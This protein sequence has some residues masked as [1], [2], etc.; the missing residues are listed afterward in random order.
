MKRSEIYKK[1]LMRLEAKKTTLAQRCAASEDAAEVRSL[2][3]ELEDVNNEIAECRD[4]ISAAEAEERSDD[5][6]TSDTVIP[7]DA[8]SVNGAQVLGSYAQPAAARPEQ[9][10]EENVLESAEYRKAFMSY[11]QRNV[12]IPAELRQRVTEY[13]NSLPIEMRAGETITTTDTGAAIPLTIMRE[14]VNTVRK[15]YGNLYDKVRKMSV[16]GG[17]E[18]PIGALEA[19]FEWVTEDTVSPNKKPGELGTVKFSYYMAELRLA[20]S[21]LS[22]IVTL[23][24]FEQ[25]FSNIIALAYRKLCDKGIVSGTGVGQMTGILNDS[26]VTNVVTMSANDIGNWT[27]WQKKFFSKLPLGYRDGEF[28]MPVSTVDSYLR[29]MHDANNRPVYFETGLE[30]FDGDARNPRGYFYGREISLVE[31]DI[32]A[33]FDAASSGD[34]IAAYWQP[35]EYIVNENFGLTVRRYPDEYANQMVTKAL[36]V[37]DGKLLNPNG[38]VLIKKA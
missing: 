7:A 10:K 19:D 36:V 31:P 33:D 15:R 14:I 34:T 38:V 3:A 25:E 1:R 4:L 8:R 27:Q 28:I 6:V 18:I 22:T 30:V 2:T 29:T 24:V 35:S 20:M 16:Q 9:R 32:I 37:L 21:F 11:V 5:P 13:R 17:V 12:P 23:D 26:R